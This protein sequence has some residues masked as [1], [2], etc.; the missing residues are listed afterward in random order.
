MKKH[1]LSIR[2][3]VG[4]LL[5][6]LA[7]GAQLVVGQTSTATI[8]GHVT[9]MSGAAVAGAKVAVKNVATGTVTELTSDA[10]GRYRAPEVIVGDYEVR[11]QAP[12]FETV[13]HPGVP[14]S[15]GEESIVDVSLPVGQATQ[16]VTVND[17]ISQVDTSSAALAFTLDT[18][19][20]QDL[21]M[22]TAR[23]FTDLINLAPGVSA[24]ANGNGGNFY[25]QQTNY[26]VSGSRP[27]GLGFL[28][29]ST[30]MTTFQGKSAGSGATGTAAGIE[31]LTQYQVL[32]NTYSAQFGGNGIVVNAAS[33]SGT[34]TFHGSAYTFLGNSALNA[35]AMQDLSV[36]PPATTAVLPPSRTAVFGGSVGGPIKKDKSFFFVNYEGLRN[37]GSQT[38][39]N[40][41]LPDIN[42]H[43]GY[44]PCKQATAYTCD[45]STGL[46]FVGFAPGTQAIMNFLPIVPASASAV[47]SL[48]RANPIVNHDNY[49]LGRVDYTLTDKDNIFLRAVSDQAYRNQTTGI[50]AFTEKDASSNYYATIEE[51][52]I[53]SATLVNLAR[54]TFLRPQEIGTQQGSSYPQLQLVPGAPVNASISIGA[55]NRVLGPNQSLPFNL[56][57]DGYE[58]MDDVIWTHG[59]HN[60]KFGVGYRVTQDFTSN[61]NAVGGTLTF[62]SLLTFLQGLPSNFNAPAPGLLYPNRDTVEKQLAPYVHDEWKVSRRLTLNLGVRYEWAANPS[63][64]RNN[65]YNFTNPKTN[66][67]WV[68]IP[69]FFANNPTNK[70][71][72]PRFGFAFDPFADHKTS[73][74]GGFGVFY[75][76][77][78]GHIMLPAYWAAYPFATVALGGGGGA[79]TVPW[80][81]PYSGIANAKSSPPTVGAGFLYGN[82]KTSTP[83]AMQYNFSIQREL[84]Q[85][86]VL[87]VAYAGARGIHL[88]GTMEENPPQIIN[89]AFGTLNTANGQTTA[90]PRVNTALGSLQMRSTWGNSDYNALQVSLTRRF[91]SHLSTQVSYSY[92][93]SMDYGS[94]FS[95]D[96]SIGNNVVSSNPYDNNVDR[97]RSTFDRTHVLRIN[98]TYELPFAK[99]QIVKGWRFAGIW[100]QNTGAPTTLT[101]GFS[102]AGVGGNS[103]GADRPNLAPGC[104]A[105]PIVGKVSEWYDPSCFTL[106]A[107]GT[108]GNLGRT[109]IVGPPF[110][111]MAFSLL[112]DT[113]LPKISETFDVQFRAEVA[114]LFNHPNYVLSGNGGTNATQIWSGAGAVVNGVQGPPVPNPIAGV[115]QGQ[116]GPGR[117]ITFALKIIF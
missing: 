15:V 47:N 22:G 94:S 60:V 92:Q 86:M 113:R 24:I 102:R 23:N 63:E 21:P 17:R 58:G 90:N 95:Q 106:P 62:Q 16:V 27:T 72:A 61:V 103:G 89:G 93:K 28:I 77:M 85:G 53:F 80:P 10:E 81:D 108:L 104:A 44:L 54:V 83:Y 20:I 55:A 39:L 79:A 66:T 105:D 51:R 88:L 84:P 110:K 38:T 87:Q 36:I 82:G 91:I 31:A 11:V 78:T 57:Q 18:Q 2:M 115:I 5:L 76:V 35:R 7:F 50:G 101:N 75:D 97:G 42:A 74:R 112:K 33:K 99:N 37:G 59:S 96:T 116:Q 32:T 67:N 41:N 109:T 56:T 73:I 71:F 65:L 114:N 25:G 98:A 68:N 1:K 34:N 26:S 30:S 64:N 6:L 19:Q 4:Y 70:N 111:N 100:S 12:G 46:A 3:W 9:D 29:D 52:H 48:Y 14:A 69:T 40:T 117:S 43:N 45:P 107:V 13:V 8:S 49:V